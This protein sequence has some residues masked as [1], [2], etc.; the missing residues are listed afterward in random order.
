MSKLNFP[1]PKG[2]HHNP[3]FSQVVVAS[4]TWSIYTAGLVSIYERGELV[5]A[6]DLAAQTAQV[7]R[8]ISLAPA[9]AGANFTDVV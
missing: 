5:S 4:E 2:L 7:M 3:A 9:T 6:G 1:H 8:N